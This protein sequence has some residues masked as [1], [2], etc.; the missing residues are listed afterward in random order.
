MRLAAALALA[1][2]PLTACT[3]VKE[4]A[5]G[6]SLSASAYPVTPQERQ[7]DLGMMLR[8]PEIT[9]ASANSLWRSGARAF[10]IDQRASR[11]GD[12]VTVQIAI[13]DSARTSNTS[14]TNRASN[15]E[16]AVPSLFGLEGMIGRLLPP[17]NDFNNASALSTE[18][19]FSNSGSGSV[20][21]AEAISLTVAAVVTGIL[22]NGNLIIE[23]TQE[24]RTNAEVRQ[25]TVSG[26]IRPEDISAANTIRHTQ[27]AEARINYGGRGDISNMQK[28][29]AG[30]AVVAK[31]WPF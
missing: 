20:N 31:L 8:Q 3:T 6:P 30:Q 14:A 2:L 15:S 28:A 26:M 29:P 16:S 12:I 17:G 5:I 11:I 25:L 9:P 13:N 7:P 27:I 19:N 24:V 23:G 1:L 4:A 10:F 18:S 22:P 21:R